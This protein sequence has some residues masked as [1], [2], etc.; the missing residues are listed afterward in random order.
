MWFE[1]QRKIEKKGGKEE[2]EE[3]EGKGG[4]GRIH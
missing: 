1:G 4:E 3:E 2:R